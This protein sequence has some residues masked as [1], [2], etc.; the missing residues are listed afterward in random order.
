MSKTLDCVGKC[1]GFLG[2]EGEAEAT[3]TPRHC[4]SRDSSTEPRG[5]PGEESQ[6]KSILQAQTGGILIHS[7][8]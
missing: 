4:R 3:T 5:K 1:I 2:V 6:L 8:G 7:A